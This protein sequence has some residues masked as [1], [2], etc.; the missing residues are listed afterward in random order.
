MRK[1]IKVI[2]ILITF[3]I[4]FAL[5]V[6]T[7]YNISSVQE[8]NNRILEIREE[9]NLKTSNTDIIILSPED[10]IYAGPMSGYYPATYSFDE[11]AGTNGTD[12]S[13]I[14]A[15]DNN[16]AI[17]I[18]EV[19]GHKN[20]LGLDPNSIDQS[21]RH[22]F[23]TE[24]NNGTMEFY[25]M[26]AAAADWSGIYI[27]DGN[28]EDSIIIII[29]PDRTFLCYNGTGYETI[30]GYSN[31]TW[32]HFRI[33]FD[34]SDD[35]HLWINN[36]SKDGGMGYEYKGNPTKFDH[37]SIRRVFDDILYFDAFGYNWTDY[38]I[39]DNLNEGLLLSFENN[40]NLD[41]MGYSL[42][43]QANKTILGNA[44]IPMPDYGQH[45]IQVFG[46]DS[47]GN[48]YESNIRNFYISPINIITPENKTYNKPM[49]GYYPA[50]YSFDD[51]EAGTT[52]T[53]I[54][55]IDSDLN[56]KASIVSKFYGHKSVLKS[57]PSDQDQVHD[58]DVKPANGSIELY[59]RAAQTDKGGS[60]VIADGDIIHSIWLYFDVNGDICYAGGGTIQPYDASTWYHFKFKFD[61]DIGGDRTND[62]HLWI[63]GE[64]K[65]GGSGYSFVGTPYNMDGI[66]I[67]SNNG[68]FYY[69]AFG[70]SWDNNYEIGDNM[71][72][73]LLLSCENHTNLN[74]M[75][76]SL[77]GQPNRTI[78][79]NTTIPMPD[80]GQH[81]IQVFGNNT[82]GTIFPSE[83]RQFTID[84]IEPNVAIVSPTSGIYG[85]TS[86]LINA[87]ITDDLSTISSA[88]TMIN[89]SEPFNISMARGVGN[90]WSCRW[91]NISDYLSGD[92]NITIWAIDE[93]G[94]VNQTQFIV[95]TFDRSRPNV[96]IIS[97]TAGT[98]HPPSLLINA[99]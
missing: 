92:Y 63:N 40:T 60:I 8:N 78:L 26:I 30:Q 36:Y 15:D 24:H 88:K 7:N 86:L 70:F 20:V 46:N 37:I 31:E 83:L 33:E 77:D 67:K 90:S 54:D 69:D 53:D 16:I 97:P 9:T 61:C 39:G 18:P 93:G 34:C 22:N 62:W 25:L 29:N 99:S 44:S 94:N 27:C 51:Q 96:T 64:S 82:L 12:I 98:Y 2:F 74:W 38:K 6:I 28:N 13:W 42:D 95:I 23:T 43:G 45:T 56:N 89:A 59:V 50:T 84:T 47:L 58:I 66:H 10:K 1:K 75:D 72:E 91:D 11:Q 80:Y 41:W 81:T 49:R 85:P 14:D 4:V 65:D 32:Y 48:N 76:Y 5:S 79:G 35:W 19:N 68:I 17:I 87:S 73:G 57:N 21:V 55:F 52:G 3:G 71:N